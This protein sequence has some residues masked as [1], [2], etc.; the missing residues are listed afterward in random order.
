METKKSQKARL[1]N[2]RGLFFN[3]GLIISMTIVFNLFE[4]K[5]YDKAQVTGHR[6]ITN[7]IDEMVPVTEIPEPPPPKPRVIA[8]EFIES[9]EPEIE[10][11]EIEIV[12]DQEEI[13]EIEAEDLDYDVVQ[14]EEEIIDQPF[15]IVEEMPEPVGG[16]SEFYRHVGENIKYPVRARKMMIEGTVYVQFIVDKE[17]RLTEVEAIKGIGGGCDIEA[18]RVV[19]S[20]PKWKPGKQRGVAVRVRMVVPIK[21]KLELPGRPT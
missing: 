3:I 16:F 2:K 20:F 12:L 17:G 15:L 10:L 8:R 14:L 5:T 11:D 18:V 19:E 21:F 1:D 13:I 7:E 9:V 6:E 4:W